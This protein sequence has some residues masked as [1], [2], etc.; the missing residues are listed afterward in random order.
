VSKELRSFWEERDPIA[1][2]R[3]WLVER[4]GID[5]NSLK[6]VEAD[7]ERRV[8][9]AVE[10]AEALPFPKSETVVER[11]F[12]PSPHDPTEADRNRGVEAI[13]SP[14]IPALT[15]AQDRLAGGGHF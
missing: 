4:A 12:A 10:Y 2:Y 1:M 11:L 14:A 15:A 6:I 3:K 5:E 9:S 13:D 7:C 8:D